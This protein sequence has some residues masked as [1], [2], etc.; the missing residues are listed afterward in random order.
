MHMRILA[1]AVVGVIAG[2][3][4]AAPQASATTVV[5]FTATGLTDGNGNNAPYDS[6]SGSFT[7]DFDPASSYSYTSGNVLSYSFSSTSSSG[8]PSFGFNRPI[9]SIL[10]NYNPGDPLQLVVD[11]ILASNFS[12]FDFLFQFQPGSTSGGFAYAQLVAGNPV[13]Y[14]ADHVTFTVTP[15]IAVATTPIPGSIVLLLTAVAGLGG[16]GWTRRR[17]SVQPA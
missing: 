9:S 15:P 1:M 10:L 17:G 16:M 8:A 6:I 11:T 2:W 7:I 3:L 12:A 5:T 14:G 4:V 13:P